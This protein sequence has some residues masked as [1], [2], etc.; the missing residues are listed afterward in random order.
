MGGS[1]SFGSYF[2]TNAVEDFPRPGPAPPDPSMLIFPFQNPRKEHETRHRLHRLGAGR[3]HPRRPTTGVG[4]L[5]KIVR[6]NIH[7]DLREICLFP[8]SIKCPS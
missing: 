4:K 1:P 6:L 2:C 5:R 3:C 7:F 8:L